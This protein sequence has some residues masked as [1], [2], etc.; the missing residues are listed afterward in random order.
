[1]RLRKGLCIALG[2]LGVALGAAGAVLPL[3]PTFPFLLLA[4]VC[5]SKSSERLHQWFVGTRLYKSNLESYVQG[6]GMT[7]R[8]KLRIMGTVTL[9]MAAGFCMMCRVPVGRVALCCV[10]LLHTVYFVWGIKTLKEGPEQAQP[11][12]GPSDGQSDEPPGEQSDGSSPP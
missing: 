3:I 7:L 9:L 5:F 2:C 8:A 12:A 11:P 6:R 1:M 10:W 4:A